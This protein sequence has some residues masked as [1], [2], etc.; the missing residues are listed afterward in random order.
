MSSVSQGRLAGSCP[1]LDPAGLCCPPRVWHG[2]G[3][4]PVRKGPPA[5]PGRKRCE[6]GTVSIRGNKWG[7]LVPSEQQV[8][9]G[10]GSAP[11]LVTMVPFTCAFWARQSCWHLGCCPRAGTFGW[12]SSRAALS[13]LQPGQSCPSSPCLCLSILCSP[14][15]GCWSS[16]NGCATSCVTAGSAG[17]SGDISGSL[18][19]QHSCTAGDTARDGVTPS[20]AEARWC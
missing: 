16:N 1:S 17:C 14:S 15:C 11:L 9:A 7:V 13:T 8:G 2:K 3:T 10:E 5:L 19:S 4:A 12:V 6:V 20:V 18:Q